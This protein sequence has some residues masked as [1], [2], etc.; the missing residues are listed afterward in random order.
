MHLFCTLVLFRLALSRRLF[1]PQSKTC[2]FASMLRFA[3]AVLAAAAITPTPAA[4]GLA[5]LSEALASPALVNKDVLWT[6]CGALDKMAPHSAVL[7]HSHS[8]KCQESRTG[9]TASDRRSRLD[10]AESV[11]TAGT[12]EAAVEHHRFMQ[13]FDVHL[14][15][16][17]VPEHA[18]FFDPSRLC[19][20]LLGARAIHTG[21]SRPREVDAVDLPPHVAG[22]T[23]TELAGPPYP[24]ARTSFAPRPVA[25]DRDSL[26][27]PWRLLLPRYEYVSNFFDPSRLCSLLPDDRALHT[28]E[29][30][31][32]EVGSGN[33]PP[34]VAGA[35]DTALAGFLQPIAS[36]PVAS[37]RASPGVPQRHA[38]AGERTSERRAEDEGRAVA[39]A[40]VQ[41]A[42][43]RD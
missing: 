27:V 15:C 20:L 42:G 16:S 17:S 29:S 19:S 3:A 36:R 28:G 34:H 39:Y 30:R 22:A 12:A 2:G 18:T 6:R 1:T 14:Q 8:V 35:T 43:Q 38:W 5:R 10:R 9:V 7:L 13:I 4:K 26:G 21:D 40:I 23:D 31:P 37:D 33:L 24:R 41:H 11:V 25:S 32:R